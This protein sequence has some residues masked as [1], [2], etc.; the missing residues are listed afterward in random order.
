LGFLR[1]QVRKMMSV[2]MAVGSGHEDAAVI[3]RMLDV[4]L[5]KRIPEYSNVRAEKLMLADVGFLDSDIC[6]RFDEESLRES[7]QILAERSSRYGDK[8]ELLR[9]M[10]ES[11]VKLNNSEAPDSLDRRITLS[12]ANALSQSCFDEPR[13]DNQ[14]WIKF[15]DVSSTL[16]EKK[17][18]VARTKLRNL[19]SKGRYQIAV[20]QNNHNDELNED[21]TK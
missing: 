5:T 2:L 14:K 12:T 6:W 8:A 18:S 3:D 19:M 1:N 15:T 16:E 20:Q 21:G 11:S 10:Y 9:S 13:M 4:E 17:E 7:A